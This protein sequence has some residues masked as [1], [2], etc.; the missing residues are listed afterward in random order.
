M[1]YQ[2]HASLRF[3]MLLSCKVSA[4]LTAARLA[5]KIVKR[6]CVVQ[7]F[8]FMIV[9]VNVYECSA[10]TRLFLLWFPLAE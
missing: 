8:V 2:I 3:L 1:S 9:V 10:V 6:S 5:V 7:Y 4:F